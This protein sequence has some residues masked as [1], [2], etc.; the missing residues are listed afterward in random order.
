MLSNVS[1]SVPSVAL[2]LFGNIPRLRDNLREKFPDAA[3]SAVRRAASI[4]TP[5]RRASN[6]GSRNLCVD[7]CGPRK[8]PKI[9]GVQRLS[10]D[11][12]SFEMQRPRRAALRRGFVALEE[13]S[14]RRCCRALPGELT[15]N[16]HLAALK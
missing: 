2:I 15:R 4:A 13:I 6:R 14:N 8:K 3:K 10:G 1:R 11:V 16:G 9:A 5:R 7:I 12:I